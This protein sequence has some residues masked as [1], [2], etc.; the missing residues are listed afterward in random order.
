MR[1]SNGALTTRRTSLLYTFAE[2]SRE[3][4]NTFANSNYKSNPK[5]F[6][7]SRAPIIGYIFAAVAVRK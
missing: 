7:D 1:K 2:L 6:I 4:F 5:S 3:N